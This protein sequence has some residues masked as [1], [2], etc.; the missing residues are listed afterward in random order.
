MEF[1]ELVIRFPKCLVFLVRRFMRWT[2]F[3][4]IIL[5]TF[6]R[7]SKR[8][9]NLWIIST[10]FQSGRIDYNHSVASPHQG[11][12]HAGAPVAS[13]ESSQCWTLASKRIKGDIH[14]KHLWILGHIPFNH[15]T[16]FQPRLLR[17]LWSCRFFLVTCACLVWLVIPIVYSITSKGLG[18]NIRSLSYFIKINRLTNLMLR[19]CWPAFCCCKSI[20]GAEMGIQCQQLR[21]LKKSSC[22]EL[23]QN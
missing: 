5:K 1:D 9:K 15:L 23:I 11:F 3:V 2:E 7:H 21:L 16:V 18:Y 13:S 14:T 12:Y 10:L 4:I 8:H 17:T 22:W 6:L 19:L 20:D